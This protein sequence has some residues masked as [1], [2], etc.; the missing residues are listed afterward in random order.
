M[1]CC[2]KI[3]HIYSSGGHLVRQSGIV[4]VEGI[5]RNI[6]VIFLKYGPVMQEELSFKIYL[7]YSSGGHLVWWSGII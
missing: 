6:S 1:E 4:L 7:I 5:I 2:L 3:F